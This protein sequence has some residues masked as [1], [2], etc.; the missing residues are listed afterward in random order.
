MRNHVSQINILLET[1]ST[2]KQGASTGAYLI[3]EEQSDEADKVIRH[4]P[5][6]KCSLKIAYKLIIYNFKH[7]EK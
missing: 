7:I 2:R 3:R 5:Q 1:S 6:N 4:L